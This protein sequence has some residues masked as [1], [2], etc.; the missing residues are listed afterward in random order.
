MRT[1]DKRRSG[2]KPNLTDQRTDDPCP[3]LELERGPRDEGVGS[4]VPAHK[5]RLLCEYL[6]H[7]ERPEEMASTRIYRSVRGTRPHTSQG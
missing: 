2:Q 1:V 6:R 4:W 5:H 7:A 3:E